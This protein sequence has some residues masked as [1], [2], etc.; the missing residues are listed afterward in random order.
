[1]C[2][3]RIEKLPLLSFVYPAQ[4]ITLVL[5]EIL[6][7]LASLKVSL[8]SPSLPHSLILLLFKFLCP[9]LYTCLIK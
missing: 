9:E 4:V 5:N 6:M 1:M 7:L 2:Q 8:H 3:I